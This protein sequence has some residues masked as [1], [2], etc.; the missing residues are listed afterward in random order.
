MDS[1]KFVEVHEIVEESIEI[2]GFKEIPKKHNS[3]VSI[4]SIEIRRIP[5]SPWTSV[6]STE[7]HERNGT[8][9]WNC[10]DSHGFSIIPWVPWI[11][12][13]SM[14]VMELRGI[15][16]TVESQSEWNPM[17]FCGIHRFPTFCDSDGLEF[18]RI[19]RVSWN[20]HVAMSFTEFHMIR[21]I[22]GILGFPH[23][24]NFKDSEG[25]CGIHGSCWISVPSDSMD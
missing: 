2:W 17:F 6:E 3:V 24:H 19:P 1:M 9:P 22:H 23:C 25:P 16:R 12:L 13:E 8:P 18:H 15:H 14:N 5:W 4:K 20:S 7:F 21:G 11:A 10:K